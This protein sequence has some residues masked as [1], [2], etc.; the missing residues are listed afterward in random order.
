[1]TEKIPQP[2]AASADL[3]EQYYTLFERKVELE[4]ELVGSTRGLAKT[5]DYASNSDIRRQ[6]IAIFEE[7]SQM[8]DHLSETD[9]G[10]DPFTS[11]IEKNS[12]REWAAAY[13]G[14]AAYHQEM[15]DSLLEDPN[16][17]LSLE[18]IREALAVKKAAAAAVTTRYSDAA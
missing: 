18:V 9:T 6:L 15:L 3:E 2:D 17:F 10:N 12:Y 1:M 11:R 16:A 5:K 13:A 4:R 7:L 8:A 14:E